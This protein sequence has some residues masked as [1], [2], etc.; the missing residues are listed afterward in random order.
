MP[1]QGTRLS[2]QLPHKIEHLVLVRRVGINRLQGGVRHPEL[3][4]VFY[5]DIV[6]ATA[7]ALHLGANRLEALLIDRAETIGVI[8]SPVKGCA[9]A[10]GTLCRGFGGIDDSRPKDDIDFVNECPIEP[11]LVENDDDLESACE[12]A[13]EHMEEP[14]RI[15]SVADGILALCAVDFRLGDL[16]EVAVLESIVVRVWLDG[17]VSAHSC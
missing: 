17:L 13:V 6:Q 3:E 8:D 2:I 9:L 7:N 15:G 11:R 14:P 1:L 16:V 5:L 4:V 12:G 10:H